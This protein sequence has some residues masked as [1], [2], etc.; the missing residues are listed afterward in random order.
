MIN[1]LLFFKIHLKFTFSAPPFKVPYLLLVFFR[2][3]EPPL[4]LVNFSLTNKLFF[5]LTFIKWMMIQPT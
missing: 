5:G 3:D 2:M 4:S 1:H